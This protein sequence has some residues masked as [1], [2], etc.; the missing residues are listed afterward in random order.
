MSVENPNPAIL[1][2][3]NRAF[4]GWWVYSKETSPD[5]QPLYIVRCASVEEFSEAHLVKPGNVRAEII[6]ADFPKLAH[7][8][9]RELNQTIIGSDALRNLGVA[10][11]LAGIGFAVSAPE[12]TDLI[13][14]PEA[15]QIVYGVGLAALGAVTV[16]RSAKLAS[17]AVAEAKSRGLG[18]VKG[19][20]TRNLSKS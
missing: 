2:A 1:A 18:I 10:M 7:L 8:S 5:L 19:L 3:R 13:K 14:S 6:S 17:F 4:P 16:R 9:D 12:T 15:L 11:V 20:F